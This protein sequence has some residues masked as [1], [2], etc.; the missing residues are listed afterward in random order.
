MWS[1][2]GLPIDSQ[3]LN[4][5]LHDVNRQLW[6]IDKLMLVVVCTEGQQ[7]HIRYSFAK[8]S[9]DNV[10]CCY[11][12]AEF[13]EVIFKFAPK[14]LIVLRRIYICKEYTISLHALCCRSYL[15]VAFVSLANIRQSESFAQTAAFFEDYLCYDFMNPFRL[16]KI[17]TAVCWSELYR[18]LLT[19][20]RIT[21]GRDPRVDGIR[22]SGWKTEIS[23]LWCLLRKI[24]EERTREFHKKCLLSSDGHGYRTRRYVSPARTVNSQSFFVSGLD[25]RWDMYVV[26]PLTTVLLACPILGFLQASSSDG[27]VALR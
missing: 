27:F 12:T 22:Y 18:A 4:C 7:G 1:L 6:G 3:W 2:P 23:R 17:R 10:E 20:H 21:C 16:S 13:E 14:I 19:R 9:D 11:K 25:A 15:R 8:M 26:Y 24:R 5:R